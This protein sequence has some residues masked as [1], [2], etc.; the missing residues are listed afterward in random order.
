MFLQVKEV[1]TKLILT[2]RNG[3]GCGS[4]LT[5]G[6]GDF[7]DAARCSLADAHKMILDKNGREINSKVFF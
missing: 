3:S 4:E 2:N 5:H 1:D 7:A 6:W